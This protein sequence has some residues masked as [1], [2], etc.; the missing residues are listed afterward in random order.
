MSD[1]LCYVLLHFD[2]FDDFPFTN[3]GICGLLPAVHY[4]SKSGQVHLFMLLIAA[5]FVQQCRFRWFLLRAVGFYGPIFGHALLVLA[6]TKMFTQD[7]CLVGHMGLLV[8]G[9]RTAAC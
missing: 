5:G 8:L 2:L 7:V 3:V 1:M 9:V 4:F 6:L